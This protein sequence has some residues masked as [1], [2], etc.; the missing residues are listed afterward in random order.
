MKSIRT[1][2][3]VLSIAA[4]FALVILGA[5]LQVPTAFAFPILH[6]S[7]VHAVPS[8]TSQNPVP[9]GSNTCVGSGCHTSNGSPGSSAVTGFPAGMTYTPGTPMPLTVTINDPLGPRFGYELTAR[10]ASNTNTAAGS[11]TAGTNS[12]L[13]TNVVPV[14]QGLA[15]TNTFTLT[16]TPP[17][18]ASGSVNFYL[19][20]WSGSFP[21]GDAYTAMYT[22]TAG[23]TATPDFSLAGSA[24]TLAVTQGSTSSA[25][26]ITVTPKNGFTGSVALT[27]SGLPSGV[28]AT[29]TPTSTTSTSSLTFTASS[30]AATGTSTVTIT[31]TSGSLTHTTTI[32]LTVNAAP[33]FS[34]SASPNSVSITQGASGTDTVTVSPVN[35]FSGSV[36][37][38]AS[39]L[40]SGVT[41]S[42]S[43][44]STQTTGTLTLTAT[45]SATTGTATVTVTGTSGSL[46]HTT[47][48]SLTVNSASVP[49]FGLSASP[50]S[51]TFIQGNSGTSTITVTPQNGFTSSV[52]LSASGMPSGVTAAFNPTSA[53]TTS[54]LTLTASSTAATGTATVTITGTSGSL[55]HTTTV[56]LTINAAPVPDFSLSASPSSLTFMQGNSGTSTVTVTPVNGFSSGVSLSASGLPTGVTAAF[57]PPSATTTSTLTLTASSSA[58]TGTATVTITGT[59]GSLTHTATVSL[60]VNA[61][62]VPTFSLS[63]SP[64]TVTAGAS[65]TSTVTIT[66]QN[67]FSASVS[68]SVSGLPSGVTGSFSPT[69]AM[70][71][72]TLTLSASSAAAPGTSTLT[73]TGTSGSLSQTATLSLTLN[74]PPSTLKV[75]PS[76]VMFNYQIGTAAPAT[77]PVSVTASPAQVLF[78]TSASSGTWLSA[79]ATGAT[80]PATVNIAVNPSGLQPGSYSGTVAITATGAMG[81]PQIVQVTLGVT[82]EKIN[83]TTTA[84]SYPNLVIDGAGNFNVAWTDSAAGVMFSRSTNQGATF[85]NNV[86]IPG[87]TGAA[88]QPQVTVDATGNNVYVAWAAASTTAGNFDVYVTHSTNGGASFPAGTKLTLGP[89]PLTDGPRMAVD[90]GGVVSVVWGR[91]ETDITQSNNVGGSFFAPIKISTNPQ[92][93]GGPRVA[94]SSQGTVYVVWTDESNKNASGSYCSAPVVTG[95][96]LDGKPIYSNTMGGNVYVNITAKGATPSPTASTVGG[97]TFGTRSLSSTDWLGANADW[98]NGFFGCSYDNMQLLMDS[99]DNLHLVWADDL[100]DQNVFASAYPLMVG[101]QSTAKF[102]FPSVLTNQPAASPYAVLDQTRNLNV[103]WSGAGAVT[104]AGIYYTRST[105]N[106]AP[107]GMTFTIPVTVAPGGTSPEFPQVGVDPAGDINV[108]WQQDDSTTANAFDVF[109]ARSFDGGASFSTASTPVSINPSTQ[110]V[111]DPTITT[112]Q[113]PPP[114]FTTCGSV[115]LG[116]DSASMSDIVWIDRSPSKSSSD[117]LFSRM[118]ISSPLPP[119]PDFYMVLPAPAQTGSS[120]THATYSLT[121]TALYGF[122]DSVA[123]TCSGLPAG[124]SCS[125]SPVTPASTGTAATVTVTVGSSVVAGTYVFTIAGSSGIATHS[126]QATLIVA[127]STGPD[128]TIGLTPSSQAVIQGGNAVYAVSV[129]PVGS[130]SSTVTV[131]CSGLPA[132]VN[133]SSSPAT[134]SVPGS[135]TVS[136]T[137][138]STVAQGTYSFTITGTSGSTSHSQ[139]A[140]LAVGTLAATVTPG[141]SGTVQ[142]GSSASFTITVNST[143]NASGIVSFGCAGLVTGI[144]CTF[145]PSALNVNGTAATTTLTV[146]VTTKPA[147]APGRWHNFRKINGQGALPS[148]IAFAALLLMAMAW[149]VIGRRTAALSTPLRSGLA[150]LAIVLISGAMVSCTGLVGPKNSGSGTTGG[151]GGTGGNNPVTTQLTVQGQTGNA[152]MTLSTLSITVP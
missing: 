121:L 104:N 124:A 14:V 129:A 146:S 82:A 103:V 29:F 25:D 138:P 46:S 73:I 110:C 24:T 15:S 126:L 76:A 140:S 47:T 42:F 137:I 85:P 123:L 114:P 21:S 54:T 127:S 67:G 88:F 145:S 128:F 68:L 17:A 117:V 41:A 100:P 13:G 70:T 7:K 118:T 135:T 69:S 44:T 18:T 125:A 72:S 147:A 80:T 65:G 31:G 27:A 90:S 4:V 8:F 34:L 64:A 59:S 84:S 5:Q 23:S 16:W 38:S 74:A 115:Q 109:F 11:W 28:T 83:T 151:T 132:G 66:P 133:C 9:L 75:T 3:L 97:T 36:S 148:Q 45:S 43:P 62:P 50:S 2:V 79:T 91:D 93:S 107:F 51:L 63:A 10:L 113:I 77:Q 134:A 33:D 143:N 152:T 48:I 120:G 71:T 39:G 30:T 40:P 20:G 95:V 78:T 96:G 35:G 119:S 101:A 98:P 116:V 56:S 99:G 142:V 37:L 108:A 139:T 122:A 60:T 89:V 26:T 102:S 141:T 22:L 87:S 6:F 1:S 130:F 53:T 57:S 136:F 81:S 61:A 86:G 111:N 55:S 49:N 150:V 92:N 12:N 144:G 19:T 105:D 52:S 112:A 94:V 131:A 149:I 32:S 58:T 106:V